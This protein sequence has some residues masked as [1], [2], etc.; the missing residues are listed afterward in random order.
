MKLEQRH[1]PILLA[2]LFIV[3][4]PVQLL[5]AAERTIHVEWEYGGTADSFRLYQEGTLLCE[6]FDTTTLAVD[7]ETLIGDTPITFTMT[8]VGPDG[9]TPHSAPFTLV[10]PEIDEFGNSIPT[11]SF[12]TD[13]VAGQVPLQV[14]FNASASSDAD[15]SLIA[16]EW[17][18]DDGKA[19]SGMLV[20]HIFYLPGVYTITLTVTDNEAGTATTS[21]SITVT[22]TTPT[23]LITTP[24]TIPHEEI[25][26][27]YIN[28]ETNQRKVTVNWEYNDRT[29]ISG[30]RLYQNNSFVCQT[31]NPDATEITCL[32][33]LENVPTT[34]AVKAVDTNGNESLLSGGIIYSP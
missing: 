12:T 24:S 15:S 29:E 2:L 18:F 9:E 32:T 8:A 19:A 14:S 16:Y 25:P 21:T 20:S 4:Q 17:D 7:C 1:Y 30:F 11:A 22:E 10:P 31:T 23:N 5:A 28:T 3:A 27:S 33:Y 6:S 34:F 13:V 26:A